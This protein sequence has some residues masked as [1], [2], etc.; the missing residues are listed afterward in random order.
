MSTK[1]NL[2]TRQRQDVVLFLL[3]HGVRG[4]PVEGAVSD[5]A[6]RFGANVT[7]IRRVWRRFKTTNSSEG[8]D[9]V[10][11]RIKGASGR[12]K[13][14]RKAILERVA[15]IPMRR[16]VTQQ[17][18]AQELGVGRSVVRDALKQGLLVR[19]SST[20]HPLL[21]LAN[22]HA[23]IRH[24]IRHVMHGPNGSY[25]VPMYN[26][27][28]VD[29]KWFNEDK[30]K[31]VFY[32]L[33]GETVPHR[34]RKS[35]RFIGKTMFLAAV[36]RPRFDNNGH[37]LFDGKIG[38]WDFTH[39]VDA[40]HSSKNRPAGTLETKNLDTVNREVYKRYL[41][42]HIIPAIKSKWPVWDKSSPIVIQQDNATPHCQPTDPDILAAGVADGWNIRLA[43]QP[44]NSPDLNTLD[45][46][47][48]A[49]IQALPYR[50]DCY[51]IV[52]LIQAI[53]KSYAALEV[54]K[55]DNI[56][57]T[58]QSSMECVMRAGGSNEYKLPHAGKSKIRR[59]GKL[60]QSFPCDL[61]AFRHAVA[62]LHEG[63]VIDV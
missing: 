4:E 38:I 1:P 27:V 53:R 43:F 29:E 37:V 3:M 18:L 14:D 16:R 7:T 57:L 51:D 10:G 54:Y 46:G 60:P 32:L 63:V 21:T 50:E 35:K 56:T 58:L 12:N 2:T 42:E 28:H 33:P 59:E 26:V 61:D 6:E 24:A 19:H 34:E 62:V 49:S 36:A 17:C 47:Y 23:R 9:G 25:F 52:Q 5:A 31:K 11:S 55:L 41:L 15:A 44:A 22:K 45:L 39:K 40:Q 8:I 20:I 48:F 13:M 30:D